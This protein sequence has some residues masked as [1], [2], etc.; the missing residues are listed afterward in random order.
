[1]ES[2]CSTDHIFFFL[3]KLVIGNNYGFIRGQRLATAGELSGYS[4]VSHAHDDRYYTETETNNLLNGK[5]NSSHTHSVNDITSGILSVAMGGTGVNSIDALKNILGLS[6][7]N[8]KILHTTAG[9]RGTSSEGEFEQPI[10]A[11]IGFGYKNDEVTTLAICYAGLDGLTVQ[12]NSQSLYSS[13]CRISGSTVML[14][15]LSSGT[16]WHLIGFIF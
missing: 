2:T 1:M 3:A 9:D 11:L 8:F 16:Y 12:L 10:D 15:S 5:A 14:E 7:Q 4:P 6:S 13:S